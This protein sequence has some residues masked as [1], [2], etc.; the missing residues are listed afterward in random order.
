[1]SQQLLQL[2]Q[3][4]HSL[5]ILVQPQQGSVME[6]KRADIYAA[7]A[8]HQASNFYLFENAIESALE[9]LNSPVADDT[10][11]EPTSLLIAEKRDAT[12]LVK[13]EADSMTAS[14]TVVG[15]YGGEPVAGNT[16]VNALK[17]NHIIKGIRKNQLQ[18]L[19]A[20]AHELDPGEKFTLPVAFGRLP[21]NGLDSQFEPLV[22]DASHRVLRPQATNDGRVDMRNLGE[23]VTV[24]A[25]QAIM[26]RIPA[27]K[28]VAG[29][30]VI[31]NELAAIPGKEFT[32][33][34]G[35]GTEISDI[36]ENLLVASKAGMPII[37]GN[38]MQV[39]DA[40][41]LK[42]VNVSTGHVNFDGSVV[43]N[44]DVMTGMKVIAT[45]SITIS[46]VVELAELKAGGDIVVADGLIG[47]QQQKDKDLA[48]YIKAGGKVTA[49]F[50]QYVEIDAGQD[51]AFSLH[52]LHCQIRTQGEVTVFDPSKRHGTLSGG[53]VNAGYSVKAVNIG[54]TA[55]VQTEITAFNNYHVLR[56]Q[57]A[58]TYK[59]L[60]HE[61]EQMGKIRDAQ[62]KLLK[63][64]SSQRPAEL[65]QKVIDTRTRHIEKIKSL[66]AHYT[67]LKS[68]YDVLRKTVSITAFNHLYTGVSCRLEKLVMNVSQEHG[69][70]KIVYKEQILELAPL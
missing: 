31:G 3:D 67:C 48:C 6:I 34:V 29:F 5:S 37:K 4:G 35:E 1:M 41:I 13:T 55:G 21:E 51:V 32:F 30:N 33:D 52:A 60:E 19:L 44:G 62:Y 45:G 70:C 17:E 25:S 24:K 8:D 28:G 47:R 20:V 46:G 40:L 59:S 22:D 49:K 12:L 50:A 57:L 15:A 27:T 39:D 36:N 53:S 9:I 66:K 18:E 61:R 11:I 68:E 23:M 16:L 58:D 65:V 56:R 26:R 63:I 10:K 69:P 38:G 14:I 54:A 64:P 2:S 43:I 42:G 7:I